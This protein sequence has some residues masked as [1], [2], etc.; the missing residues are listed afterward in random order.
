MYTSLSHLRCIH[1]L[2]ETGSLTAAAERL[3]LTQS[4]LSH[5][6]KGLE[7]HFQVSLFRRKSRP[8]HLTPAGERLLALARDVLPRLEDC[9]KV[10]ECMGRGQSGR[11]HIAIECHS[12]FQWL[13]PALDSYRES[14]PEVE[15]DLTQAHSFQPLPAL[16]SGRVDLVISS[17]RNPDPA[18]HFHPLFSYESLLVAAADHPLT[19]QACVRP[20]DLETETLITYPVDPDRLDVFSR[21]LHPAGIRPAEV[22]C[23]ELTPLIVQLV[24]SGRGVAVL[25]GWALQEYLQGGQLKTMRLGEQGV[26]ATL[27]AVVRNEDLSQDYMQEF[28]DQARRTCFSRLPGIREPG[29]HQAAGPES[30]RQGFLSAEPI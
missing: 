17:D 1:A 7:Q 22:R 4:A 18:L 15:L 24:A 13:M 27:Y 8:L 29:G 9:E 28:L 2:A 30:E 16:R 10:L 21:F 12:C 23:V 25:P 20:A 19:E 14:R 11:L 6:I 3:H 26:R 5:Q